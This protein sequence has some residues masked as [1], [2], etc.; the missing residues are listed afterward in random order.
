M[1]VE[2]HDVYFEKY[3]AK[4]AI[5]GNIKGKESAIP[6]EHINQVFM[7]YLKLLARAHKSKFG[8]KKLYRQGGTISIDQSQIEMA[9]LYLVDWTFHQWVLARQCNAIYAMAMRALAHTR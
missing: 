5:Y 9:S 6:M 8:V 3:V 1:T 4:K 7:V 2:F